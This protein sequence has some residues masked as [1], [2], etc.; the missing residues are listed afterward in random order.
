MDLGQRLFVLGRL[1]DK[2]SNDIE[3]EDE[4]A[5]P[6]YLP[7]HDSYMLMSDKEEAIKD[8]LRHFGMIGLN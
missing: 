7:D 2:N 4:Q 8:A 6:Y 1:T 5:M 3:V